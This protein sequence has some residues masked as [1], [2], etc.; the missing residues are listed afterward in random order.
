MFRV[1][2]RGFVDSLRKMEKEAVRTIFFNGPK[3]H[4]WVTTVV[5]TAEASN[6]NGCTYEGSR[7][8]D[9]ETDRRRCLRIAPILSGSQTSSDRVRG[10]IPP[11]PT[12]AYIKE[13][14]LDPSPID[15]ES[16]QITFREKLQREGERR[17]RAIL[18][19]LYTAP[20]R[21]EDLDALGFPKT[22]I[23]R[24]LHSLLHQDRVT[25][26]GFTYFYHHLR[27]ITEKIS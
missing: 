13:D 23:N 14:S 22:L 20:A 5:P 6:H 24:I 2:S 12:I 18:R 1:N 19:R 4:R 25:F 7:P 16:P 3:G 17:E 15:S 21:I 27:S 9:R 8:D 10:E 11:K 26:H